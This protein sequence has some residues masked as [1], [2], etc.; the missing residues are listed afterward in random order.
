M[1]VIGCVSR[2]PTS[3]IEVQANEEN[4]RRRLFIHIA[5]LPSHLIVTSAAEWENA[6]S[7]SS[8]DHM[9]STF[10]PFLPGLVWDRAINQYLQIWM[11][12]GGI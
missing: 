1:N 6:P 10:F 4:A 5:I 3:L 11:A 12:I 8:R 9:K 7:S 2:V